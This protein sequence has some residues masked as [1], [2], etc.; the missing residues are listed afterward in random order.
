MSK[1]TITMDLDMASALVPTQ[2]VTVDAGL[3]LQALRAV[4]PHT[5][6]TEDSPTIHRVRLDVLDHAIEALATSR[7]TAV[8][9]RL[10]DEVMVD[11]GESELAVSVDLLPGDLAT[12]VK[13]FKPGKD[14]QITL[15]LDLHSDGRVT[16]TDVS[17]LFDGRAYTVPSVG[18][19]ED[20]PDVR[21][22]IRTA[23]DAKRG[24]VGTV[25]YTGDLLRRF[26]A[27]S[28][29]YNDC[30]HIEPTADSKPFV[31]TVGDNFIGVLMPQRNSDE[32]TI[33][34][35]RVADEWHELLPAE[36]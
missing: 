23:M 3:L 18:H 16:F 36:G 12:I 27:S 20:F 13:M 2:L 33:E 25:T 24:I 7:Y 32:A 28:A 1:S 6:G 10:A 22:L 30:L 35:R 5:D 14:E 26:A 31:V 21:R 11:T 4:L 15:R 9:A 34:Q 19:P 17:G 29:A 8:L